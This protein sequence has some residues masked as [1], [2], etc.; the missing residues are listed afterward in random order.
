MERRGRTAAL[1]IVASIDTALTQ[2]SIGVRIYMEESIEGKME[3]E[4]GELEPASAGAGLVA[5]GQQCLSS[6]KMHR[7]T[8]D[9]C[10]FV[11]GSSGLGEITFSLEEL[12]IGVS[13]NRTST[14]A[15]SKSFFYR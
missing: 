4:R 3:S 11:E 5:P 6:W 14:F 13:R 7:T 15:S 10:S 12:V 2:P 1:A 9:D 8:F